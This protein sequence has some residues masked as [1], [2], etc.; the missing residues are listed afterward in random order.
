M[1]A[2]SKTAFHSLAHFLPAERIIW[3]RSPSVG[4]SPILLVCF[5]GLQTFSAAFPETPEA[6]WATALLQTA[7]RPPK[8]TI[9]TVSGECLA[10][11]K[12][13]FGNQ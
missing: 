11:V 1:R 4:F 13:F 6:N 5:N 3:K 9:E 8:T 2:D 12:K 10:L 7:N